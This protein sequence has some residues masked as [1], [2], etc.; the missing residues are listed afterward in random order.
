MLA[1]IHHMLVTERIPLDEIIDL[2]SE[3]T[4]DLAIIEFISPEDSMFRRISRGRDHLFVE[5]TQA[6]FEESCRRRF[7]II[8]SQQVEKATRRLYLL[9]KKVSD[10]CRKISSDL[11]LWRI[12]TLFRC[13]PGFW[14]DL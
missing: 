9:R 6:V 4:T 3:L 14:Q 10:R 8:R 2:A 1:V 5:L 7:E 12:Y 13:G 11:H